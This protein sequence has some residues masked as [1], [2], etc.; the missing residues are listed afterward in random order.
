M[1]HPATSIFTYSLWLTHLSVPEHLIGVYCGQPEAIGVAV[2]VAR[3]PAMA[4]YEGSTAE[5]LQA[6]ARGGQGLAGALRT[7][8]GVL[9]RRRKMGYR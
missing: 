1:S 4:L 6:G 5:L 7:C 8:A 9:G 3:P 2:V